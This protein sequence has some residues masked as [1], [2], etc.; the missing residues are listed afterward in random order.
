VEA[1]DEQEKI[2]EG[3]H[4]RFIITWDR[5][6]ARVAEKQALVGR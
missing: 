6:M 5:F 3:E 4:E 2:G 1:W